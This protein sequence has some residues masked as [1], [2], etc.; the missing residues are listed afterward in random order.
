MLSTNLR[1]L[2]KVINRGLSM[3]R[4]AKALIRSPP[5]ALKVLSLSTVS[6]K[7]SYHYAHTYYKYIY[8]HTR[9]CICVSRNRF[10]SVEMS[11]DS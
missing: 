4:C 8:I 2:R 5:N 1:L 7:A 6:T 3:V 11:E 9:V 10:E